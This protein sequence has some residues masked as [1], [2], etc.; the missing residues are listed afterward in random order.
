MYKSSGSMFAY[1]LGRAEAYRLT[2]QIETRDYTRQVMRQMM[3]DNA[4]SAVRQLKRA[5]GVA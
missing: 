4:L 3:R 5:G 2:A 1:F